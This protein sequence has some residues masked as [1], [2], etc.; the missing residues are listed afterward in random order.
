MRLIS[1]SFAWVV[2]VYLGSL[3]FPPPYVLIAASVL[4]LLTA[5]LWRR[6][7]LVLWGGLCAAVLIGG[8]AWHHFAVSEPTLRDSGGQ[9]V[10]IEGEVAQDPHY[11]DYGS[12]FSLSAEHLYAG[13]SDEEVSGKVLVYTDVLSSYSQGD[14]LRIAGVV[15]PLSTITNPD[16]RASLQRQGFVGTMSDPDIEL[17]RRSWLFSFRD[18]L[19]RSISSAL[20]EPQASLA[21]GLLLGMR[22]H[23]PDEVREAF[24]RTGT[25]HILA[26]S[27]FHLAIIG[28]TIL[29]FSAWVFGRQRPTY[30]VVTLVM[31]W[32]YSALTGMQPP[33]LRAAIMFSLYLAALWLG[34]PGSA[35]T[36]LAFAAAV[37]VGFNP[38]MLW[39]VSFQLSFMAVLGL[40]LVQPRFQQLGERF[41][42]EEHWVSSVLKPLFLAV[43]VGMAAIVATLPLM[44]YYFQSLSLV[45]L[46]ATVVA[47]A[48][49][50]GAT[51]LSGTTAL[52]GLLVPQAAWVVGWAAS[53]FLMCLIATVEWFARSPSAF[54]EFGPMNAA[55][56]WV[57]YV[58]LLAIVSSQRL[59]SRMAGLV[60]LAG[61]WVDK[62]GE[63]AYRLPKKWTAGALVVCA[64]LAW[65]A[66][67][68]LPDTRL[69]ISFLDVG[70]GDAI[71]IRTPAGQQI[72]IDGGPNPDTV[73]QQLGKKMPFW[74]KS[75]D[76]VVLTHSDDDH[77]VGLMGVLEHYKVS[78]VVES[79]FGEGPIY[80]VWLTEMEERRIDWTMVRA[81]QEIDLGEGICLEVIYPREDLLSG[82]ESEANSNSVVLRL[83]WKKVSFLFTGDVDDDAERNILYGGVLCPL[84]CTVLKVAHHGSGGS[85]CAEF[86]AA[87]NPQVAVIS[88]GE[89]NTFGHPSDETLS[90]LDGVDVYRTDECGTVTFT[91]DGERLWVKTAK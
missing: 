58:V 40:I 64:A 46:P 52:T 51:V 66:F 34:R 70:Q 37:M 10:V 4:A 1:L 59:A 65:L 32:L 76:M 9:T 44:V 30:L 2:G 38:E 54:V 15:Q 89:G 31:V 26:V 16:Y 55:F 56:V 21:Q 72:L 47:S 45:G 75:L 25:S 57:Y 13:D 85:T 68:T 67:S 62:L 82:T 22:S 77:L 63:Y 69:E 6:R 18:R 17:L 80:R 19:A 71:L 86:V 20:P 23:M 43:T 8:L 53:F 35:L 42:P 3:L 12:W 50:P 73:C 78:H 48:F 14:A 88:V 11:G 61:R 74:D 90:R 39:T 5:V 49:V 29:S 33:I 79:G 83:V 84:R 24:S 60:S 7:A 41:I 91:T 87:V 81:G 27:G 28:G 36:A